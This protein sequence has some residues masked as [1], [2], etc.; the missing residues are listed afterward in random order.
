M[1]AIGTFECNKN[2]GRLELLDI[3]LF[4]D[5]EINNVEPKGRVT[6]AQNQ[7]DRL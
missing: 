6:C 1:V 3:K 2:D 5:V 4:I 7:W